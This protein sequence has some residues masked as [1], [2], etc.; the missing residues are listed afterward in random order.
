MLAPLWQLL[1]SLLFPPRCVACR[2][3]G[4]RL[5]A[6][7]L[8]AIRTFPLP[9]CP[10]CDL[11]YQGAGPCPRCRRGAYP[12]LDGLRALG[13]HEGTLR[14]AIHALKYEGQQ[15]L[16]VPLAQRL[17]AHWQAAPPTP[18]DGIL[19]I[20]L[21]PERERERGYNQADLL[22]CRLAHALAL[23]YEPA[24]LWRSQATRS[25]VSLGRHERQRNLAGAF[26]AA[27]EVAGGNWLLVDDVCTT[28]ATLEA[29]AHALRNQGAHTIW[30]LTLA[31]AYHD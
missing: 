6:G 7:C 29:A 2:Q 16:A 26:D 13:P 27:A 30:A 11:P 3:G 22:A 15:A 14:R 8:A 1:E 28:G 5:C 21:H 12:G 18:L 25:Q 31:R 10:R 20:P 23:P 4:E 17:A 9:R 24:W 19:A